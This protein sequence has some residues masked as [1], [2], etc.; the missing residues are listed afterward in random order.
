[1]DV[2]G[3]HRHGIRPRTLVN[4]E[5]ATG[6]YE[7]SFDGA[8]LGSGVYFYKLESNGFIEIRKMVLLK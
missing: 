2:H 5:L 1:M 8:G 7:Y 3:Y 4:S 6:V